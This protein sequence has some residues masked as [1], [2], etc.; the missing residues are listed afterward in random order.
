[1]NRLDQLFAVQQRD[2]LGVYFTAG[3]PVGSS[4]AAMV[5]ELEETGADFV[6]IGMPFSDPLADGPVIQESS[7]AALKGGMTISKLFS[8]LKDLRANVNLP[9]VLMGY[10]NP[11]MQYGMERF[12][13]SSRDCGVDAVILPDLP[14]E[15][16]ERDYKA[17]FKTYN[18]YPVFLVA[19]HTPSARIA[20]IAKESKGFVYLVSSSSTTGSSNE[21]NSGQQ[22]QLKL[23]IE[24]VQQQVPVMVGFGIHDAPSFK[25]AT[26]FASGGIVGSALIRALGASH[27][28]RTA[29]QSVIRKIKPE[30]YDHSVV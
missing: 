15:V 25:A 9:V 29:I 23:A 11:V 1:M 19:P 12:L 18:V 2:V 30:R 6:E 3:Y 17:L 24:A 22:E 16:Y 27:D 8:E 26:Q 10:L 5:Q 20:R 14:V 21:L 13:A 28:Y 4:A 7:F